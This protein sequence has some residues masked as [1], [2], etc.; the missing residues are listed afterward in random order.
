LSIADLLTAIQNN[1]F[2]RALTKS[3]HMVIAGLQLAH[4][5]GFLLLLSSLLLMSLRLSGLV[6]QRQSLPQATRELAKLF[7]CGLVLA[8]GSG[9]LMFLT[10]PKHYF[11]NRA[12][13]IK[14]LLLLAALI[15]QFALLNRIAAREE[16]ARPALARLSVALSLVF[17]FGV[18]I[19][20]RAIGF[21]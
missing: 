10:G 4:V 16:S 7:Q 20:G 12:F 9:T 15:V 2:A 18:G 3:N 21:V 17:W 11:Y 19:A 14:M 5:F 1:G 13:D 6:L 8:V